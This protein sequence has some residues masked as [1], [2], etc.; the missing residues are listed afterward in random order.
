MQEDHFE[1]ASEGDA[2]DDQEIDEPFASERRRPHRKVVPTSI[3]IDRSEGVA[4]GS[5]LADKALTEKQKK[6]KQ[7]NNK[8]Y[9]DKI[10]FG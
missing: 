3:K 6:W 5:L 9:A 10:K 4:A 2:S 7:H 1:S 8:K